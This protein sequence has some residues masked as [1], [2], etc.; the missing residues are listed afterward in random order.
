MFSWLTRKVFFLW[1]WKIEGV[2]PNHVLKKLYVV[3][4]HTSNWDFPLGILMKYG[5]RMKVGFIG[6]SSLF[7]WPFGWF[8][9]G[10]GGIPVNRKKSQGFIEAVVDRINESDEFSTA[11]APEGTR[12]KVKKLKSGFYHIAKKA[13]IP[14]VYIKFD[15]KNKIVDYA[16]P[17]I[18]ADT[19]V[20][21][22]AFAAKYFEDT[23]GAVPENS[24]GYPFDKEI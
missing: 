4:P 19:V 22:M 3:V 24:F 11:I 13:N 10:V 23:V 18:P 17:K 14:I 16:V 21:E 15:W 8:F 9:K 12:N 20:E 1:G 2:I 5:F 7:K 6:K